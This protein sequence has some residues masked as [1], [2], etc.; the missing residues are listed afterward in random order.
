MASVAAGQ[1]QCAEIP[2]AYPEK[3]QCLIVCGAEI[4]KK[5][6]KCRPCAFGNH[7][8]QPCRT[9]RRNSMFPFDKTCD[10]CGFD[11]ALHREEDFNR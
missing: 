11:L 2:P 6:V 8:G 10:S 7:T 5:H 1:C 3:G 9:P 4:N